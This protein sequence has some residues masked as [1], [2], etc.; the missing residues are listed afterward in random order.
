VTS[1]R[2]AL[3][4]LLCVTF[5]LPVLTSLISRR[6]QPWLSRSSGTSPSPLPHSASSDDSASTPSTPVDRTGEQ[7]RRRSSV[8]EFALLEGLEEEFQALSTGKRRGSAQATTEEIVFEDGKIEGLM[9]EVDHEGHVRFH[10]FSR[11]LSVFL[12]YPY[13]TRSRLSLRRRPPLVVNDAYS[14]DP[15][16]LRRSSTNSCSRLR[17]ASTDSRSSEL[18]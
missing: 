9:P 13:R 16:L 10:P 4:Y 18:S 15:F 12:S 14:T 17:Q 6:F 2:R 11:R 1:R 7:G 5:V 8:D 3:D